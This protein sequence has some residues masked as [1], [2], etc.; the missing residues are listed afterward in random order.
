MLDCSKAFKVLGWSPI[1]NLVDG[2]KQTIIYF[3]EKGIE[4]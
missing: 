2:L 1:Y 4:K 3:K